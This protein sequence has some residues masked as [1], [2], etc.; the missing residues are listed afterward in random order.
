MDRGFDRPLNDRGV[1]GT[2]EAR[3]EPAHVDCA[4]VDSHPSAG[5][6]RREVV[7]SDDRASIISGGRRCSPL[8]EPTAAVVCC[9]MTI[10]D[11]DGEIGE[12]IRVDRSQIRQRVDGRQRR[13]G[14]TGWKIS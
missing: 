3:A 5:T 2:A 14:D 10:E 4:A 9:A 1:V 12:G 11:H 13:P 7:G 6:P 8:E